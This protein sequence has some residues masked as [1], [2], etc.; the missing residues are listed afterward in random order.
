[1]SLSPISERETRN[2]VF[3]L[4]QSALTVNELYAGDNSRNFFFIFITE[5]AEDTFDMQ[6]NQTTFQAAYLWVS[7]PTAVFQVHTF[8]PLPAD[9]FTNYSLFNLSHRCCVF[10]RS[11]CILLLACLLWR[12]EW[13]FHSLSHINIM[14]TECNT[15]KLSI[16]AACTL[17]FVANK[18]QLFCYT[19]LLL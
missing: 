8:T 4:V 16:S 17:V 19:F 9:P 15:C 1:M 13:C 2:L 14:I 18:P 10:S 11:T 12:S 5:R 3:K 7:V 6:K